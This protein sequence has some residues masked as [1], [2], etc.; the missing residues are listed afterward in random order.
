M[1]RIHPFVYGHVIGAFLVGAVAGAFLDLK[2]VLVFSSLLAA[3]AA[4]G[5]L[6][7]WWR[8]GFE[9][10]WWKL[11]PVATFANPMMLSAIAFSINQYDCLTG[12]QS[13]WNCMLSDV[14][15]LTVAACLPSPII[16]LAARWLKR[17]TTAR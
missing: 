13:G 6:V 8:P 16:G 1:R 12:Q 14:G 9:A 3:N 4:I 7:C 17:R 5:S 11:W 2:A 15:P 10:A